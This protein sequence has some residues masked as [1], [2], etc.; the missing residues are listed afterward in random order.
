MEWR[1]VTSAGSCGSRH[2]Y[3]RMTAD[4]IY[5]GVSMD[6]DKRLRVIEAAREMGIGKVFDMRIPDNS[7]E[8]LLEAV[9]VDLDGIK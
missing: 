6:K 4:S 8:Y 9:P 5:L 3:A 1:L 2:V 7:T